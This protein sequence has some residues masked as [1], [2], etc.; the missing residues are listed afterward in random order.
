MKVDSYDE[1][2]KLLI[3]ENSYT[4]LP[5]LLDLYSKMPK[6]DWLKLLGEHWTGFDNLSQHISELRQLIPDGNVR[7][8]MTPDELIA[9]EQLPKRITVYRG[10][11]NDLASFHGLCWTLDKNIA[12]DFVV[13]NRYHREKPALVTATVFKRQIAAIKLDRDEQEII[14]KYPKIQRAKPLYNRDLLRAD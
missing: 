2:D 1:V 12:M 9:L 11:D 8:M 7:Q 13:M 3:W 4:A 14:A 10:C 6:S 5:T